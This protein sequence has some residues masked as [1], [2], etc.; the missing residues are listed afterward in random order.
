MSSRFGFVSQIH[1]AAFVSQVR[2]L[3]SES[4]V[5]SMDSGQ[6][7]HRYSKAESVSRRIIPALCWRAVPLLTLGESNVDVY[8]DWKRRR[9]AAAMGLNSQQFMQRAQ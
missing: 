9:M 3:S 6:L 8:C 5:F 4:H 2:Q 1:S 7:Q